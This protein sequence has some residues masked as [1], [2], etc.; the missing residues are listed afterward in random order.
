MIFLSNITLS[1]FDHHLYNVVQWRFSSTYFKH[2]ILTIIFGVI[3]V[4]ENRQAEK[5]RSVQ[6][7][8]KRWQEKEA[9]HPSFLS[10]A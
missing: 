9:T 4:N 2:I 1:I 8:V 10:D 5:N 7:V 6:I 3:V